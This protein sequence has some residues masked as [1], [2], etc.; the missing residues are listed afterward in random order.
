MRY[1]R[2]LRHAIFAA[3]FIL[4]TDLCLLPGDS[5]GTDSE[6]HDIELQVQ[7][8]VNNARKT[9]RLPQLS[10]NE[11]L[12]LEAR[13]HARNMIHKRFFSHQDP[14]RGNIDNRLDKSG[15]EWMQCGE[16]LYWERGYNDPAV[17]AVKAWLES[18]E[19]RNTM[20]NS[21]FMQ[22]G[23]FSYNEIFHFLSSTSR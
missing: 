12:A 20:L 3:F 14:T 23:R 11:Q 5:A 1:S 2:L 9:A 19:H 13:R 6:L 21:R 4:A 18:P 10:W 8:L 17:K 7:Q 15:I 22:A 16:N